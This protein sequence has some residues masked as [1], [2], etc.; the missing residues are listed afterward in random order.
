[1]GDGSGRRG[2]RA[3]RARVA[4]VP[5]HPSRASPAPAPSSSCTR[6]MSSSNGVPGELYLLCFGADYGAGRHGRA[7][8]YLGWALDADARVR[9]HLAGRGSP[10]VA[11]AVG[12]GLAVELVRVEPGTRH[13]ERRL[14]RG[15][16]LAR[17]CP[18]CGPAT[19][20]DDRRRARARA[21]RRAAAGRTLDGLAGTPGSSSPTP[22]RAPDTVSP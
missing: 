16:R 1:M 22:D 12:A 9:E 5:S 21:R 2:R 3:G 15:H 13:D 8:H 11:A 6:P 20:A 10:L 14:K 18:A 17:W 19:R 4:P 7:R